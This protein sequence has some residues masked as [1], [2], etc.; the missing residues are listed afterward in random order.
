MLIVNFSNKNILNR[1]T[2]QIHGI[3]ETIG[4]RS[5]QLVRKA[6]D[7]SP[8]GVGAV[9]LLAVAKSLN[10]RP[11]IDPLLSVQLAVGASATAAL[12]L[13]PA[14][15]KKAEGALKKVHATAQASVTSCKRTIRLAS[16]QIG[17]AASEGK[18]LILGSLPYVVEGAQRG[19]AS[20]IQITQEA[21]PLVQQAGNLG[22][23]AIMASSRAAISYAPPA[24]ASARDVIIPILS[25]APPIASTVSRNV[26]QVCSKI[27][28]TQPCS[29]ALGAST[30]TIGTIAKGSFKTLQ[31]TTNGIVKGSGA[32]ARTAQFLYPA[33]TIS[34]LGQKIRSI[35]A[36]R[37]VPAAPINL[38]VPAQR[39]IPV[40]PA[41][42]TVQIFRGAI[43]TIRQHI[44]PQLG[45]KTLSV[46]KKVLGTLA[47]GSIKTLQAATKG[48]IKVPGAIARTAKFLYPS[49]VVSALCQKGKSVLSQ[50]KEILGLVG[51]TVADAIELANHEYPAVL[52]A[53][54]TLATACAAYHAQQFLSEE[55][56]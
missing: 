17:R 35:T 12:I 2:D 3:L 44:P 11:E 49:Q 38:V 48:A 46:S 7:C 56:N 21:Y 24:A 43:D 54:S 55:R 32:I 14:L 6:T 37:N 27:Q 23:R 4:N 36:R 41:K 29:K 47:K 25:C 18:N 8:S 15:R 39:N 30:K 22:G 19:K 42:S 50:G 13:S 31:L 51:E 45:S 5:A 26:G 53:A 1:A 10:D 34:F 52:G 16:Q 20:A 33:R 40:A 28:E 9:A